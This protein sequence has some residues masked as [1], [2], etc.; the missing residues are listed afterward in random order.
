MSSGYDFSFI[1]KYISNPAPNNSGSSDSSGSSGRSETSGKNYDFSFIDKYVSNKSSIT[2]DTFEERLNRYVTTSKDV[3]GTFNSLGNQRIYSDKTFNPNYRKWG[4]G[5]KDSVESSRNELREINK[6]VWQNRN[7]FNPEWLDSFDAFYQDNSEHYDTLEKRLNEYLSYW[8]AYEKGSENIFEGADGLSYDLSSDKQYEDFVKTYVDAETQAEQEYKAAKDEGGILNWLFSYVNQSDINTGDKQTA[9]I[10]IRESREALNA[11]T[12]ARMQA[13]KD[14]DEWAAGMQAYEDQ[15][16][17]IRWIAEQQ[18]Q[19]FTVEQAYLKAKDRL[20]TARGEYN[21]A[22][23]KI[24]DSMAYG[25]DIYGGTGEAMSVF[26]AEND[27]E[28]KAKEYSD[29]EREFKYAQFI[30]RYAEA[31]ITEGMPGYDA[32]VMA[33]GISKATEMMDELLE[34]RD[35]SIGEIYVDNSDSLQYNAAKNMILEEGAVSDNE[36]KTWVYLLGSGKQ[37][38]A[39]AYAIEINN[40]YASEKRSEKQQGVMDWVT[41]DLG[42]SDI[43]QAREASRKVLASIAATVTPLVTSPFEMAANVGEYAVTGQISDK[44]TLSP[45]QW[46]SAV[47]AAVSNVLNQK[48]GTLN[49]DLLVVGGKGWGDAYQVGMSIIQSWAA[50]AAQAATG[51]PATALFFFSAGSQGIY[52]GL[53]RGLDPEKA[54]ALG[55]LNGTAEALGEKLSIEALFKNAL[56]SKDILGVIRSIPIQMLTEGSEEGMTTLLNT[57]A[58]K[59]VNGD[60]RELEIRVRELMSNGVGYED[61]QK[62]AF[63]EWANNIASDILAGAISGGVSA[64]AGGVPAMAYHASKE[65]TRYTGDVDFEQ[66]K[67]E[68]ESVGDSKLAERAQKYSDRVDSGKFVSLGQAERLNQKIVDKSNKVNTDYVGAIENRVKELGAT[69][70]TSTLASAIDRMN[71]GGSISSKEADLVRQNASTYFTVTR[72]LANKEGWAKELKR[73][74]IGESRAAHRADKILSQDERNKEMR[75]NKNLQYKLDKN[76]PAEI[77]GKVG[78]LKNLRLSDSGDVQAVFEM[79]DGSKE[80]VS[81]DEAIYAVPKQHAAFLTALKS[82]GSDAVGAFYAYDG[83]SNIGEYIA[84]YDDVV[85]LVGAQGVSREF[86]NRLK[87]YSGMSDV[88]K[89]IAWSQGNKKYQKSKTDNAESM[90][91]QILG[92]RADAARKSMKNGQDLVDYGMAYGAIMNLYGARSDMKLED[93]LADKTLRGDLSDEQVKQAFEDGREKMRSDESNRSPVTEHSGT[94]SFDGD[95]ATLSAVSKEKIAEIKESGEYEYIQR[96]ASAL[97]IDVVFFESV[98]KGGKYIGENGRYVDGVIYLDVNAGMTYENVG[99]RMILRT[100]SH[101]LTHFFAATDPKKYDALKNFI[102]DYLR[103]SEHV[104][105]DTLVKSKLSRDSTGNLS[106]S[107]AIDEVIADTCETMLKNSTAMQTL[108]ERNPELHKSFMDFV[109]DFLRNLLR[110]ISAIDPGA[111]A[112]AMNKEAQATVQRLWD[113]LFVDAAENRPFIEKVN[114]KN[115]LAKMSIRSINEEKVAWIDDDITKTKPKNVSIENH[116]KQH[117]EK[118][119]SAN[120]TF[121]GTLPD[122]GMSVYAETKNRTPLSKYG[123]AE[124]YV[125]STYTQ[126]VKD[127]KKNSFRA[128]MKAAGVLD[129]L[130]S[131]AN[132]RKWEKTKH[133]QNKDAKYGVYIYNSIFAFPVY[134]NAGDTVNVRAYDCQL[135]ILNA[136]DGRKYLYDVKEIKENT[137]RANDILLSER[138][139]AAKMAAR[140][141]DVSKEIVSQASENVKQSRRDTE[142]NELSQQQQEFFK[143]SVV[144]DRSGNLLV[145]YHQ[146][147]NDFTVFDPRRKGAG[148]R[149]T[150]TPY[151]IFLKSNNKDIG[152]KGKK[153]MALYVNIK[154]PLRVNNRED[155][156]YRL[157]RLSNTYST[158][159]AREAS[160]DREYSQKYEDAQKAWREYVS[161]WS[162]KNPGAPRT[163]IYDDPKYQAIDEAEDAVLDEWQ[164]ASTE[165]AAEIKNAITSALEDNGYD[166]IILLEDKGSFG[167]ST[168]AYIALHPEQVKNVDNK[169]PTSNLDIRFSERDSSGRELS[170]QQQEY[171]KDSKIRDADGNL[172][173]VYHSTDADFT[174]FDREKLGSLTDINAMDVS[175]AATSHV[176]FWFNSDDLREKTYQSKVLVGYLNVKRPYYAGTLEGLANQI[177]EQS[178]ENYNDLQDRFE[179]GDITVSKE[180]GELFADWL[181]FE[182]Y[183]GVVVDDEEFGGTSYVVFNPN[184]FKSIENKTPTES[185]DIRFS[186]RDTG[187]TD[188]E[189]LAEAFEH[190]ELSAKE[191]TLLDQYKQNIEKYNNIEKTLKAEQEK[192]R[193][194]QKTDRFGE[195][196]KKQRDV[197]RRLQDKLTKADKALLSLEAAKPLKD[198]LNRERNRVRRE[199]RLKVKERFDERTGVTKYRD[200]VEQKAKALSDMLTTNTDKAHVPEAL[201]QPLAEF[202]SAL[203]FSSVSSRKGKGETKRDKIYTKRLTRL[204][205]VI[206]RQQ[207]YMQNPDT[208]EGLDV[209]L[210]LPTGFDATLDQLISST[211]DILDRNV[212]IDIDSPV[213]AMN[214]KQLKDL[215]FVLTV[216][217]TSI[218]NINKFNESK[219]YASVIDAAREGYGYINSLGEASAFSVGD[220]SKIDQFFNWSNTLPYYAFKRFG[221]AGMERFTALSN[222]WAKMAFNVEEL[223]RFTESAYTDSEV[224]KWESEVHEITI[225]STGHKV[226]MTTAQIMSLYCLSNREQAVGHL[227]GGGM[228]IGNIESGM[229]HKAIAQVKSERLTLEDVLAITG[230]LDQRQLDVARNLQQYMATTGQ[231]WGNEISLKR[232]GYRAFD[233]KN[234]F[235]I[236]T[237]DNLRPNADPER[238]ANDLFR[239]LNI[240]ATKALTPNANNALV[241][242]SIFDVFATNMSDMAKYNALALPILDLLK[243][244]NFQDKRYITKEDGQMQIDTESVQASVER[245]F[246]RQGQKYVLNLIKDLNGVNEGGRGEDILTGFMGK[247]KSVMVAA[248]IRV[249]IQQPTAYVRAA[250]KID[251]KY[252]VQAVGM[253]G[254]IEEAMKYSGLAVWKSLGYFDTNIARNMRDQIKHKDTFVDKTL[255][256]GMKLAEIGDKI[257]WGAIWNACKLQSQAQGLKGDA[258]INATTELFNETILSTQVIDST[259]SRSDIMRSKSLAVK[260]FTSFRSEPTVTY[261]ALLDVVTEF[262]LKRRETNLNEARRIAFPKAF[263][264]AAVFFATGAAT[265]LAAALADAMRDDDDYETFWQKYWEHAAE[266]M[267]SN[268]NP[269]ALLPVVS[270]LYDKAIG[271]SNNSLIWTT[272]DQVFKAWNIGKEMLDLK[273][274]KLDAP[275]K[276]TSYGRMT[277]FGMLYNGALALS[278]LSGLPIGPAMREFKALYNTIFVPMGA[279]KIRTYDPGAQNSIKYAFDDGYITENEAIE[280]LLSE[281]VIS[282]EDSAYWLVQGWAHSDDKDW[283]KFQDLDNA[284]LA[285]DTDAYEAAVDLL[286]ERGVAEKT[287]RSH[288]ASQ[289][290][291]WYQPDD[292]GNQ[293]ISKTEAMRMLTEYAGYIKMEAEDTIREWSCAVSSEEHIDY[294]EIGTS[295]INGDISETRAKDMLQRYGGLTSKEASDKVNGWKYTIDTGRNFNDLQDAFIHGDISKE[296]AVSALARY[297]GISRNDASEKVRQWETAKDYGIKYGSSDYGIKSAYVRG[298]I[299]KDVAVSIMVNYGGKTKQEAERYAEQYDFAKKTGY[300]WSQRQEAFNAGKVSEAE[301][302]SW[303]FKIEERT[304]ESAADYV[305]V[306]KWK[307]DVAGAENFN[308]TALGKWKT[309]GTN[310][311]R[312]GV[313]KELFAEVQDVCQNFEADKDS[314]HETIT[315]SKYRKMCSYI[316]S[317]PISRNAKTY[318]ARSVMSKSN[319]GKYANW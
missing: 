20:D 194:M 251:P 237:D 172:M 250:I 147:E 308:V 216:L 100:L 157:T 63:K 11:A 275:T 265:S 121:I 72:E 318:L 76:T 150:E 89:E 158:L 123:L 122:S 174:V 73:V 17:A 236:Q 46:S 264:A 133:Q 109:R 1:D 33:A 171:F 305:E 156:R 246:G 127:K 231:K 210:D 165:L 118:Q 276:T 319:V 135:V 230:L 18:A 163:A 81:I 306:A 92:D 302:E 206:K 262:N 143:D 149:D 218:K 301:L 30:G 168:D 10:N 258:L 160:L 208:S 54:I 75:E 48:H 211:M 295:F 125:R 274:G 111:K 277:K 80:T 154:N 62:V 260:E 273:T 175:L 85:N 91:T 26:G 55:V 2:P 131:I 192:L 86:L 266:N 292:S 102:T 82:L 307:R 196:T 130:V 94:V 43:A 243:W 180:I 278:Y 177:L 35:E 267:K 119:I 281:G 189:L 51:I 155:L 254:G 229:G 19:G 221:E 57:F 173:V 136:S 247:A 215:D 256:K 113:E 220:A 6:Y 7:M 183:D 42:D 145:V 90:F 161:D 84:N 293:A 22:Q 224:K 79:K 222:G 40:K 213:F 303:Y 201:K 115:T 41:A 299:T 47:T 3:L 190:T 93:A 225:E 169:N 29:A 110:K 167:R 50:I 235:P 164:T 117:I 49:D 159:I 286:L 39:D 28:E 120:G 108:S 249:A 96:I 287:I 14:R 21:E 279:K 288:M 8:E 124:E 12:S 284:A 219:H 24:Q 134:N 114:S 188:R 233:E 170:P 290:K 317:L 162:K 178:G 238:K 45:T 107:G 132:G 5:I 296:D 269:F 112:L 198:V 197:V 9:Q 282:N 289:I 310:L 151:G 52:D 240:S 142:G 184:Q 141:G 27:I 214:S 95:G 200:R 312:E 144:R 270:D 263:R 83:K 248:N 4:S 283:S 212:D 227:L 32:D 294:S 148:S 252:L 69:G 44:P 38:E 242:S 64:F 166:G 217:G 179:S 207:D 25:T 255:E 146:T 153:Q 241:V 137:A 300:N 36:F 209:F 176:G 205:E 128:K 223:L 99:E 253:K 239:L 297:G 314:N 181:K 304:W 204:A 59:L 70:D 315:G 65:V 77:N 53:E 71:R 78:T 152:L 232:F 187:K 138:Q 313:S 140:Q 104:D 244:Y 97:G 191:K 34:K 31:P 226:K 199:E 316:D 139:R 101:E 56:S 272:A 60:K 98:V 13:Q 257:T 203:D 234:Y 309:W 15:N 23:D 16:A 298:E 271:N 87:T 182:G 311:T 58:D 185:N 66:M 103:E 105:F 268:L 261:N 74:D 193:G 37:V 285:K 186:E 106:Y 116:I 129:D 195:A 88:Q 68:A 259:I 228:R 126:W 291:K 67:R 202:L 245:A 280:A 61:A